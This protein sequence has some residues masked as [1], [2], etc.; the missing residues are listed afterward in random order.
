MCKFKTKKNVLSEFYGYYGD[1]KNESSLNNSLRWE[2][3]IV[4]LKLSGEIDPEVEW[5]NPFEDRW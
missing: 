5:T 1:W 3:M 2:D 4:E